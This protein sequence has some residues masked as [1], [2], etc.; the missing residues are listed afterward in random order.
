VVI[1]PPWRLPHAFERLSAGVPITQTPYV[2][3]YGLTITELCRAESLA[4]PRLL[5][6][7]GLPW[8]VDLD[9]QIS[10]DGSP[11][12]QA[13]DTLAIRRPGQMSSAR[14]WQTDETPDTN[15][16]HALAG[17]ATRRVREFIRNNLEV[18]AADLEANAP[19]GRP[20][21]SLRDAVRRFLDF[22]PVRFQPRRFHN[23]LTG[24]KQTWG[25]DYER[26]CERIALE[27]QWL[28]AD[29]PR[30]RRCV[31][32]DAVFVTTMKRANCSWTLWN[33]ETGEEIQRCAPPE[34]FESFAQ[35]A[36]DLEHQR[37][38]K[39]LNAALHRA[40]QAAGGDEN[41]PRVR[42]ARGARDAYIDKHGRR[43]GPT[44]RIA[45][46]STG[47]TLDDAAQPPSR[48]EQ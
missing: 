28:Y 35:R 2:M 48:S 20:S 30:L 11:L 14:K 33:A 29:R 18:F 17:T 21:E 22:C 6:R 16:W 10:R 45:T 37:T 4:E 8:L 31:L 34:A 39:R 42:R 7:V 25:L 12:R 32:C 38:R 24:A 27:L 44:S 3:T 26:L 23:R 46:E 47:L 1:Q 15:L 9:D 41:D 19:G 43:R 36:S 5:D 13:L 40:R